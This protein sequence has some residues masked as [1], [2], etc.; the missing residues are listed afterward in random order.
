[1]N[2]GAVHAER[3]KNNNNDIR[4]KGSVRL[5]DRNFS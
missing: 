3:Y 1:M 4:L 5:L 2:H